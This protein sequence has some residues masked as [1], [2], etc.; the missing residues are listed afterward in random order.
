MNSEPT[1]SGIHILKLRLDKKLRDVL[2]KGG[3]ISDNVRQAIMNAYDTAIWLT[4]PTC[5]GEGKIYG[6]ESSSPKSLSLDPKQV[7][8]D[9]TMTSIRMDERLKKKLDNESNQTEFITQAVLFAVSSKIEITCPTCKGA[10]KV[11]ANP[12]RK[13]KATYRFGSGKKS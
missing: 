6:G 10:K 8:D 5:E 4:C 2:A 13:T 9:S 11:F 1:S 3:T 12:K 7:R